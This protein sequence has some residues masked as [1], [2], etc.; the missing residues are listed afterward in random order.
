MLELWQLLP[1]SDLTKELQLISSNL[2]M[3][4]VSRLAEP[5][6]RKIIFSKTET[7]QTGIGSLSRISSVV[8]VNTAQA[9]LAEEFNIMFR[10]FHEFVLVA[11]KFNKYLEFKDIQDYYFD[12]ESWKYIENTMPT[13]IS[14]TMTKII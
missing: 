1:Y 4:I 12:N 7:E 9:L 3:G 14:K 11:R 6:A 10:E 5:E 13:I 8:N 2:Y